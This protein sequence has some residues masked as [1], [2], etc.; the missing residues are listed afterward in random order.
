MWHARSG[1]AMQALGSKFQMV[2]FIMA[3]LFDFTT[4]L[5]TGEMLIQ[6]DNVTQTKILAIMVRDII[7]SMITTFF[8]GTNIVLKKKSILIPP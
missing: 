3:T 8:V 2:D 1:N 5:S 6:Q 4:I 7:E